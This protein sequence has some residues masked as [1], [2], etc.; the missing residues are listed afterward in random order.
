[1]VHGQPVHKLPWKSVEYFLRYPDR[2]TNRSK[3]IK[4]NIYKLQLKIQ[5]RDQQP[6]I[7]NHVWSFKG[8]LQPQNK[9]CLDERSW[10]CDFGTI[11]NF[12]LMFLVL[13]KFGFVC[14]ILSVLEAFL[15][16]LLANAV[17]PINFL[18]S[19]SDRKKS[20]HNSV[21]NCLS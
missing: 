19:L 8:I 21:V 11:I 2:Q 15:F 6:F 13:E 14:S 7:V 18:T 12:L 20:V 5:I 10:S 3:N 4:K 16:W 9:C 1:M 17:A